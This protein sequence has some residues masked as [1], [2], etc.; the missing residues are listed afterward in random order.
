[1]S[2]GHDKWYT[3]GWCWAELLISFPLG[4][5]FYWLPRRVY[6]AF[7]MHDWETGEGLR[8]GGS[9]KGRLYIHCKRCN[10]W[11]WL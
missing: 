9:E 11:K 10:K 2:F 6:C 4:L 3:C 7:K 8:V 5:I 1:M